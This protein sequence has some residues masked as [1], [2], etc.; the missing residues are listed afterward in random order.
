VLVADVSGPEA[1]TLAF[2][3][4][5]P[6]DRR[7]LATAVAIRG[8]TAYVAADGLYVIDLSDPRRPQLVERVPGAGGNAA[9]AN[10][11]TLYVIEGETLYVYD[12]AQPTRP[13]LVGSVVLPGRTVILRQALAFAAGRLFVAAGDAGV[14]AV[15]VS[16]PRRPVVAGRLPVLGRAQ[17]VTSDGSRLYVG[18]DE[19]GLLVVEWD[20]ATES[21]TRTGA[22]PA[23]WSGIAAAIAGPAEDS[24]PTTAA[25][26][27]GCVVSNTRDEG[28]NSLRG[29]LQLIGAGESV[30]FDP[31]IFSPS[32]PATIRVSS[33]L[34]WEARGVTIDGAGG[35]ILDGGGGGNAFFLKGPTYATIR[36]LTIR[37]FN[38]AITL[39]GLDNTRDGNV[40]ENNVISGNGFDLHLVHAS[41]NRIAGNRIG[42][43]ASATRIIGLPGHEFNDIDFEAGSR[44]NQIVENTFGASVYVVDAG[45]SNNAFIG[46]RFGVDPSGRPLDCEC[47]LYIGEPYN[48]IGG[49]NPDDGNVLGGG[50]TLS[51]ASFALGNELGGRSASSSDERPVVMISGRGNVVGGRAPGAANRV[52]GAVAIEVGAG[53]RENAI[54][55]NVT[56]GSVGRLL[57]VGIAIGG[58]DN[59]VLGNEVIG[60]SVVGVRLRAGASQNIVAWNRILAGGVEGEDRGT[61]N[62]W[63]LDGQGNLWSGFVGRDV[64]DDGVSD[65]PR[66][67]PPNGT[68]RFPLLE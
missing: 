56:G 37:G 6:G 27:S 45:S 26:A 3:Q 50:L 62:A 4:T 15:D 2:L 66:S 16:D 67:V 57:E 41:G 47:R 65:E 34:A 49:L 51:G 36:G 19:A 22:Q 40:I 58:S 33:E 38:T 35:V 68:D 53:S 46:N 63:D 55:D 30:V 44:M 61:G 60:A 23:A 43:D 48:Q 20:S 54:V 11:G 59:F 7:M 8:A 9:L 32:D 31:T 64:D 24:P 29:C 42:V 18:T 5:S 1:C 14:I 39:V 52:T 13:R 25:G 12:L 28:A 17:T 21:G 10:G